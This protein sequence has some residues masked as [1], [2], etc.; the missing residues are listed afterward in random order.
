MSEFPG[1][2]TVTVTCRTSRDSA[3]GSKR[4]PVTLYPDGTVDTGHD[5]EQERILAALGG[6]LSCLELAD[7]AS[8]AVLA[9]FALEQRLA[10][11]PIR[12]TRASGPWH[13]A[14]R[15][16]CCAKRGYGSPVEAAAHARDPKHVALTH[17]AHAYQ[18]VAL[19]RGIT[20]GPAPEMPGDPWRTMWECGMHPDE[21]DRI[22]MEVDADE[23]LPV[24]FYLGV[25]ACNP[26]LAWIRDTMRAVPLQAHS[27]TTLAWSYGKFDRA[28]P[29]LRARWLRTG[30]TDQL[31][32]RLMRSP[33]VIADIEAFA[34]HWSI[35][36]VMAGVELS[37]WCDSG[38]AP[39]VAMLTA[40]GLE[41]LAYPPTPPKWP[42]RIRL[43]D[44][45]AGSERYTEEEIALALVRW[46]SVGRAADALEQDADAWR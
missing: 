35:S 27:V 38:V 29:T 17:Q 24:Q 1:P 25:M 14:K 46:G 3:K 23:P 19:C 39:S 30:I 6:Y 31:V 44:E 41:H 33:Y 32:L 11:R 15:A 43:R 12:A 8:P 13:A 34:A 5:L 4:H 22:S 7:S 40:P 36:P 10:S 18:V 45:L 9:W 28:D 2:V 42:T 26:N 21:V 20:A 37:K 16:H